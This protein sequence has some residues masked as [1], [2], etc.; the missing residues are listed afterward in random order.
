MD[1]SDIPNEIQEYLDV[2]EDEYTSS[3]PSVRRVLLR[4]AEERYRNAIADEP[5]VERED[6]PMHDFDITVKKSKR[7]LKLNGKTYRW[8]SC[9]V[10]GTAEASIVLTPNNVEDFGRRLDELR[11]Q[12][13]PDGYIPMQYSLEGNGNYENSSPNSSHLLSIIQ[14]RLEEYEDGSYVVD[15]FIIRFKKGYNREEHHGGIT[16]GNGEG[17]P[18]YLGDGYWSLDIFQAKNKCI[19]NAYALWT[20]YRDGCVDQAIQGNR[21]EFLTRRKYLPSRDGIRFRDV[22]KPDEAMDIVYDDIIMP[23]VSPKGTIRACHFVYTNGHVGLLVHEKYLTEKSV[24]ALNKLSKKTVLHKIQSKNVDDSPINIVTADIESYRQL[25]SP[26]TGNIYEHEPLLIGQYNGKKFIYFRGENALRDYCK[27][28]SDVDKDWLIW[29]HN[30]GR[31]DVHFLFAPVLELCDTTLDR[32]AELRD[33][34]GNLLEVKARLENGHT[35]TFRDSCSLMPESLAKLAKDMDVTRKMEDID[36]MNASREDILTSPKILEY[37]RLDCVSLYEVLEKYQSMSTKTF[38]TNPLHHVSASSFAKKIF[39]SQYYDKDKYPLYV[40]PRHVRDF[41]AGAYGGGRNEV[42]YRGRFRNTPIFPY[43]FT[44]FYPSVGTQPIPYGVPKWKDN[45]HCIK[46]KDA[47]KKFLEKNPGFYDVDILYTP[48]NKVPLHGIIHKHKYVFPH[49]VDCNNKIFSEELLLGLS[50][51][52]RYRLLRGYTQQLSP[53]CA[54]FFKRMAKVRAKA[55][56]KGLPALD[57][58]GKITTNAAYGYFGFNPY[59]RNVLRIYG[60]SMVEHM[61]SLADAGQ[62]SYRKEGNAYVCYE[63]TDI[64]LS[65]INVSV[66]AAITSYARMKLWELL[67]DITDIGGTIYYCDTDSVYSSIDIIDHPVLGPKWCGVGGGVNMGELKRELPKGEDIVDAVY[68]GCKTYGY[69]TNKARYHTKSKGTKNPKPMEKPI[70]GGELYDDPYEDYDKDVEEYGRNKDMY[71]KLCSL[72]T[73]DQ[74]FD[75][76]TIRT[77]RTHKINKDMKVYDKVVP[78]KITGQYTKGWVLE[79]GRVIPMRVT[80]KP[81]VDNSLGAHLVRQMEKED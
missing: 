69:V 3:P 18:R 7:K 5:D 81:I 23:H 15:R 33:L 42:F 52:Y 56:R 2:S 28:L 19:P 70:K 63:R 50:I 64:L 71:A 78:K 27:Y 53:T 12:Y 14:F 4:D 25:M 79:D 24:S 80:S 59:D 49:F 73:S 67:Q 48:P 17:I 20:M 37:N 77:S 10:I 1:Y 8:K 60:E 61:E 75:T 57:R 66:A 43:D 65:D 47:I 46:G 74:I 21:L 44:G 22:M 58:T 38:G 68:V 31:Y 62:L 26:G 13:N 16:A 29:F 30:G 32:P 9:E 76:S 6:F 34:R 40:Y 35:I 54:K 45:L 51:G 36:I 55:K 72:L 41:I 39:F 11:D